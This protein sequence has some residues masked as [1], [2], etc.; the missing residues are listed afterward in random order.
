MENIEQTQEEIE[1]EIFNKNKKLVTIMQNMCEEFEFV[2]VMYYGLII[3]KDTGHEY[4]SAKNQ[5]YV[6]ANDDEELKKFWI[7]SQEIRVEKGKTQAGRVWSKLK[8]EWQKDVR[9][10]DSDYFSRKYLADEC[11]LK[12]CLCVPYMIDDV[13]TGIVEFYSTEGWF[14]IP[15]IVEKVVG[16]TNTS[17]TIKLDDRFFRV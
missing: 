9:V 8:Y 3:D 14:E 1:Y 5:P 16:Y 12:T 10:L 15:E 2:V 17:E 7:A 4:L 13:F 6:C 11:G